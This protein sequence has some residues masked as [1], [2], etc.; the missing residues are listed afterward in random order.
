MYGV[1]AMNMN[2]TPGGPVTGADLDALQRERA[3][4]LRDAIEA[5]F[6]RDHAALAS[7]LAKKRMP[8]GCDQQGRHETRGGKRDEAD[9]L[10]HEAWEAWCWIAALVIV[11]ALLG[12]SIAEF[13]NGP[14]HNW[15][16]N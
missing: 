16:I 1:P 9:D 6:E 7:R 14:F 4:A 8:A 3:Q 12:W 11:A 2:H 5:K 15:L 10:L 13:A